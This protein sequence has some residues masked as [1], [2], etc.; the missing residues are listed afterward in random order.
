MKNEV[1][2]IPASSRETTNSQQSSDTPFVMAVHS[3]NYFWNYY[4]YCKFDLKWKKKKRKF[5]FIENH[6][7]ALK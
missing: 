2:Y 4:I 6:E 5:S 3:V 7:N 1:V